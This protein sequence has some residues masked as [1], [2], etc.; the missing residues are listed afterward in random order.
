MKKSRNFT[1][2]ILGIITILLGILVPVFAFNQ[3]V[4]Y[5]V[6]KNTQPGNVTFFVTITSDEE[7]KDIQ[8]AIVNL[9]YD[10]SEDK[11]YEVYYVKN[12]KADDEF[13]YEF[14]VVETGDWVFVDEIES[15]KLRTINGVME[16]EEKLGWET[17]VP[18][19]IFACLIGSFMIF[20]NFFNNNS[21]NRT[22]EL[23]EIIASTSYSGY[24]MQEFIEK[25]AEEDV[26][27][28]EGE[29]KIE[30]QVEQTKACEYCG[31]LADV[32]DKVCA[33][34]GAKFKKQ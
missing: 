22:I 32:N 15:V 29:E 31:T 23:K 3:S 28:N 2:L 14:K 26:A 9:S 30:P 20:V 10:N 24:P 4:Y 16:V 1:W 6:E 7:I 25:E 21:K 34:C 11:E 5:E 8:N 18:I 17:R 19:I 13:K 33:S 27:T 12:V